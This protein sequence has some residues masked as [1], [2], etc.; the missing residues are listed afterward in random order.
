MIHWSISDSSESRRGGLPSG[1][2]SISFESSCCISC[3][4]AMK[5]ISDLSHVIQLDDVQ[6]REKLTVETLSLRIEDREVK[7][8]QGK[9]IVSVKDVCGGPSG[10]SVTWELER[11]MRESYP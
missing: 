1:V 8:L 9:G 5:Y 11:Q 7:H 3:V 4:S 10:G 2:A 6:I